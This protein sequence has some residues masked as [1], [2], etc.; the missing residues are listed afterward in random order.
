MV[1][2]K[3][4]LKINKNISLLFLDQIMSSC[5]PLKGDWN[6]DSNCLTCNV[7]LH[8]LNSFL[9]CLCL[10]SDN[11]AF[12]LLMLG[13]F[14]EKLLINLLF[15]TPSHLQKNIYNHIYVLCVASYVSY[16]SA[17]AKKWKL[18]SN[19]RSTRLAVIKEWYW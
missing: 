18:V 16:F 9:N 13:W 8:R 11:I 12:L 10:S 14:T 4:L 2:L 19:F 3:R 1:G 7:E 6:I 5:N 17:F 15:L